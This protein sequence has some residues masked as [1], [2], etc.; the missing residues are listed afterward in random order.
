ML[1]LAASS[2]TE[3]LGNDATLVIGACIVG[4]QIV[5][6]LLSPAVGR[7]AERFGRRPVLAAGMLALP[8]RGLALAFAPSAFFLVPIQLLDGVSGAAFGVLVPLV[9]SDLT[10][11]TG[12]FNLCMG[13]LGLAMGGGAACSTWAAG[14]LADHSAFVAF[15]ALSVAGALGV[16]LAGLMPETRA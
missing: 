6:A 4:P 9:A 11:G 15:L 5:V 10:R 1:P 3:K 7:A 2:A 14:A 8:L 12:R 16:V 13:F